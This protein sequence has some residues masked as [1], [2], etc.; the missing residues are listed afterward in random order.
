MPYKCLTICQPW[1]WA[2]AQGAK[3]VEN[4]TWSTDYRGPLWIH[5]GKSRAW[6]AKEDLLLWPSRYGVRWPRQHEL[7]FGAIVALAEL[8]DCRPIE[9]YPG[10]DRFAEGPICWILDHIIALPS[11]IPCRGQLGLFTPNIPGLDTLAR[12][13]QAP[14]ST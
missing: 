9:D 1:A 10:D 12:R 5:A 2:I 11:P 6:L 8:I 7:V 13:L 14:T 4:R 3:R